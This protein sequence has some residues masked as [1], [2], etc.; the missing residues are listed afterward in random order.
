[1]IILARKAFTTTIEEELQ[2]KFKEA[3]DKNGAKMNNV[4]E[5][6]MKSYID[7]EFQIEL[8]YKLTPTKSK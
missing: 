2:R 4:I 5:A 1:V 3:C 6:F 7:G 8:I